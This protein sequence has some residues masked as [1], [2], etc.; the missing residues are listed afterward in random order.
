MIWAQFQGE[1]KRKAYRAKVQKYSDEGNRVWEKIK[2]GLVYGSHGFVLEI[3]DRFLAGE[4]HDELPQHNSLFRQCNPS[5]LL[6]N[7]SAI[8]GF[9]LDAA[10][11]AKKISRIGKDHRDLLIYLLRDAGH[12]SNREIGAFFGLTYS[13]VSQRA[14]IVA[15]RM[16]DDGELKKKYRSLKSK[17]K[18]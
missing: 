1:D 11:K 16:K 2:H 8:L 10:R 9:D 4:I 17:I 18:G 12:M 7:A 3:K 6:T 5:D 13:A 14:K 15:G